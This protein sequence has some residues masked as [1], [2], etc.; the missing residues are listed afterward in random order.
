MH[1]IVLLTGLTVAALSAQV[2]CENWRSRI[3]ATL[4][5]P[6]PLPALRA[7]THGRFQAAPGVV[8]ERV[9]YATQFNLRV[10]AVIYFPAERRGKLPGLVVVNGHGGDKYSW[11]AFYT[12]ILY[13]RLGAVVLTYD[14]VGEGERNRERKSGTRAHDAIKGPPELARR[15]AGLMITDVMQ[16][17]SYLGQ[18]RE[19][20]GGR[21]AA[22]GYSM[23]SFVLSL[24]CAIDKRLKACVLAGGGN[25]DGPGGYWD[26]SKPMCQGLPYQSLMF[27]GD[28]A[29]AIYALHADRGATLIFNGAEDSTVGIPQHR[30]DASFFADLQRRVAELRGTKE[31]LFDFAFV[32]GAGHRPWFVTKPVA[33]WLEEKLDFPFC[34]KAIIEAMPETHIG[35][36]ARANGVPLDPLYASEHREGGTLAL[37]AGVPALARNLLSVF[38]PDTW[39]RNKRNL[40]LESWLERAC[41]A[42]CGC[43]PMSP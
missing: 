23:G 31:G 43:G 5:V 38:N 15:L 35:S 26:K 18:R 21:I 3:K 34:T 36:W 7:K 27:L 1:R 42:T 16:A 33:L 6:E 11:Y 37:G 9:T 17:V 29:A 19:V 14:P 40:I 20:D 30:H 39:E 13:A 4:F 2:D 24:A 28:R 10:P 25:L 32:S 22:V 8:A 12:G 41:A